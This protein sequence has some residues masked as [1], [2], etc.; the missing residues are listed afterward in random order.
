MQM[1]QKIKIMNYI[2]S[3]E[4]NQNTTNNESEIVEVITPTDYDKK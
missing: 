4:K 2:I 1:P 3:L